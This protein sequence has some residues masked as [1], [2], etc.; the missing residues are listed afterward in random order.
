MS[1]CASAFQ[2]AKALQVLQEVLTHYS[3]ELPL[4]LACDT[5]PYGVGAVLSHVMPDGVEKPIAYASRTLGKAERNYAQIEREA[6]AIVFGVPKFHQYLYGNTFTL[7]TDHRPLTNILSPVKS[8]PYMAQL[9][10]N[11][12]HS[13]CQ[14][15]ITPW[16]TRKV[17]YM[18]MLMYCQGYRSLMPQV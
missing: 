10:C 2:K 6:L 18:P 8:T 5:L 15:T 16:R 7:P 1:A 13:Y 12:D 3:P 9:T 14:L 17:P 11:A 4:R